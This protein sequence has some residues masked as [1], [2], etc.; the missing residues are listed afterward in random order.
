MRTKVIMSVLLLLSFNSCGLKELIQTANMSKPSAK[1][2]NV[3][4]QALT[5]SSIDLLFEIKIDNPNPVA[6]K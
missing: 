2:E 5:F 4:V 3:K 1:L 6:I